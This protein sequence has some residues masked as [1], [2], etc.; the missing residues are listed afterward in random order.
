VKRTVTSLALNGNA[1]WLKTFNA[2]GAV[3]NV[4]PLNPLAMGPAVHKGQRVFVYNGDD[5]R[6][7]QTYTSDQIAHLKL[8][9]V[10]GMLRGLGPI[11]A[12]YQALQGVLDLRAYADNW[13]HDTQHPKNGVLSTAENLFPDQVAQYQASWAAHLATGGVAVLGSGLKF[14]HDW[15]DP[16]SAQFLEAQKFS[17]NEVGRMF[18]VPSSALN[19]GIDGNSLTYATS[20]GLNQAFK[21]G[22]LMGYLLEIEAAL[23]DCLPRGQEVKFSFA[24][25]LR[26]D[27]KTQAEVDA[28]LIGAGILTVDEVRAQRGLPP[29]T[30]G[31][32]A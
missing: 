12:N 17:V 14:D 9:E 22:T 25:W 21:S 2:S 15:L 1:Y 32:A 28:S 16:E 20:E 8:L 26:P 3:V 13:F 5:F 31:A 18:G 10:P 19:S 24:D 27:A 23:S 11:Q 7:S 6:G 30:T 4:E 29:L